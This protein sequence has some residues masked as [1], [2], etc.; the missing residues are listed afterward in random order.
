M[1]TRK[2]TFDETSPNPSPVF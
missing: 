2:V 1:E